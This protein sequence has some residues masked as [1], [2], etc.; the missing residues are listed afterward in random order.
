MKIVVLSRRPSLY[1][2]RRLVEAG[3][4][5]G[6]EMRVIDYLRCYMNITA[7]RPLV[8]YQGSSHCTSSW[9]VRFWARVNDCWM[10]LP[11]APVE[12]AKSL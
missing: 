8:V 7:H 3:I 11:G 4:R 9:I 5:R 12:L 10:L 6:H 1:S 2:T